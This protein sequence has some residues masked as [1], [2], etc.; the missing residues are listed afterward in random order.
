MD[1]MMDAIKSCNPIKIQQL[2]ENE[3]VVLQS[4]PTTS[5]CSGFDKLSQILIPDDHANRLLA[6]K[7]TGDGNCLYNAV[8]LG[9]RGNKIICTT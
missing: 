5:Y 7:T 8:S 1:S 2:F 4:I 9:I 3:H 6:I